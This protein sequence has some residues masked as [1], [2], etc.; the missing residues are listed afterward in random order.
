MFVSAASVA[1]RLALVMELARQVSLGAKNAKV[2][3]ARAGEGAR[4]FQ[5]ITD[6]IN[7]LAAGTIDLARAIN[8]G[9]LALSR[10]AVE[11]TRA[12]GARDRFAQVRERAASAAHAA[13]LEAPLAESRRQVQALRQ[14]FQ[15]HYKRLG[16]LLDEIDRSMRA[17]K[18]IAT[19]A[20]VE[21]SVG[22]EFRGNLEKIASDLEQAAQTIQEQIRGCRSILARSDSDSP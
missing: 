19:S 17:G 9:A 22:A 21:A 16:A 8:D 11:E 14:R 7:E 18:V 1:G 6:F 2:V 15:E 10:A 5:P 13:S 4:G 20:R 12:R 3:A